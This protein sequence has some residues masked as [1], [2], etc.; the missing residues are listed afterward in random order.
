MMYDIAFDISLCD[1]RTL[2]QI[3]TYLMMSVISAAI[4]ASVVVFNCFAAADDAYYR[5]SVS[6]NVAAW[7]F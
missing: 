6:K 1:F 3:I 2:A 5:N 7:Y 4:A